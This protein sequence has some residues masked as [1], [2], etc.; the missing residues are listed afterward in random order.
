M[1]GLVPAFRHFAAQS[2]SRLD[3]ARNSTSFNVL[4]KFLK[5]GLLIRI[6]IISVEGVNSEDTFP[7]SPTTQSKA[8]S[9]APLET[10]NFDQV[11]RIRQGTCCLKEPLLLPFN[12]QAFDGIDGRPRT[13]E[14]SFRRIEIARNLLDFQRDSRGEGCS[15]DGVK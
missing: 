9:R 11:R 13:A 8:A 14:F 1:N 7:R 6:P 4:L 2:N 15:H 12:E 5:K 10:S 3:V